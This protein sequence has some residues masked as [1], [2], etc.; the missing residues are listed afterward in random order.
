MQLDVVTR[1]AVL[2]AV[3]GVVAWG[4]SACDGRAGGAV[5][6]DVRPQPG[7]LRVC[8]GLGSRDCPS[9]R[10]CVDD[11]AD[12]CDPEL[13]GVDC[14]GV[15]A[16]RGPFCG[17]FG[18]VG[19]SRDTVCIDEPEDDCDPRLGGADCGGVCV[20]QVELCEAT[21]A[22]RDYVSRDPGECTTMLFQCAE[23]YPFFDACGCGC[24]VVQCGDSV[25][26]AGEFCCNESCGICAPNGGFCTQE[27]CGA[28]G[29]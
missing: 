1:A 25:C 23:G 4:L 6:V 16:L 10:V 22:S 15:C 9:D 20:D 24:R 13:G 19:C 7:E 26:S 11:P 8:A 29:L 21:D 18:G 14:G 2:L 12:T 28:T 17:G 3:G 27:F 5:G